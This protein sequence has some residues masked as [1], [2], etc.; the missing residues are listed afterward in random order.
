MIFFNMS[1]LDSLICFSVC[2]NVF[3]FKGFNLCALLLLVF[4]LD[5][6]RLTFKLTVLF[7][8]VTEF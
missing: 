6:Q 5:V 3:N 2:V 7:V 8:L 4:T 1:L